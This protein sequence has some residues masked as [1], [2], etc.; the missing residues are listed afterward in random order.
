M[1]KP[2]AHIFQAHKGY[3]YVGDLPMPPK[4]IAPASACEPPNDVT[5]GVVHVLNSPQATEIRAGWD[6]LSKTWMPIPNIGRRLA[7]TSEYLAA[8]GWTYKG[9]AK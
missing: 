9:I 2:T 5:K 7:F 1:R 3:F 4:A 8:H 6:G